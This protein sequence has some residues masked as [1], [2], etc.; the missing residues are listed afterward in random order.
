LEK[1]GATM[2]SDGQSRTA[3]DIGIAERT[4]K[5]RAS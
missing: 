5:A 3:R 2:I 4:P 1:S